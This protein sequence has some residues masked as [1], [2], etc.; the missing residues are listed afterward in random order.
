MAKRISR[1]KTE[2]PIFGHPAPL[3]TSQLPTVQD[4]LRY[5]KLKLEEQEK[6]N[7]SLLKFAN[8]FDIVS[9]A[10][11]DIV[12]LWQ[13]AVSDRDKIPVLDIKIVTARL[14]RWYEKCRVILRNK[15]KVPDQMKV[16]IKKLFDICSCQC[17]RIDCESIK[18]TL[19]K[20]DGFH[21]NCKCIVKVPKRE[22]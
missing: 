12:N 6:Q 19:K 3:P 9:I 17:Q 16:D 21:L 22:I 11:Q 1:A 14:K 20:C 7:V 13:Q 4:A 10:A 2:D 5:I 8:T 15:Q 18:C